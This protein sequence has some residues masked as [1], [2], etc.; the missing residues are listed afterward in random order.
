[1]KKTIFIAAAF[2][3]LL[4]FAAG[5]SGSTSKIASI[6]YP[7]SIAADDY[8]AQNAL[9]QQNQVDEGIIESVNDF[10]FDSAA[11]V[12]SAEEENV[13]YSPISLYM[14]L[15]MLSTGAEGD[16]KKEL[17]QL[18]K[19]A[20]TGY[21]SEQMGMLYRLMYYD[22]D[23]SKLYM[24]NSLW[25]NKDY[26]IKP[27]FVQN[28][29]DKFYAAANTLDFSDVKSGETISQWISDN[30]NGLLEP[31]IKVNPQNLMLILNTI[32]LNDQW[33]NKFEDSVTKQDT[34]Y[35][36]DG[37]SA[38]AQFMYGEFHTDITEGDGYTAASLYMKNTG[39]MIFV[40]PDEG[41]DTASIL[42]SADVMAAIADSQNS[43]SGLV[44]ISL[45]KFD[46]D[47]EFDLVDSLRRLGMELSFDP[48]NANFSNMTDM[49]AYVSGVKQ[50]SNVSVDEN[51]VE[52]AAYTAITI[53]TTAAIE[54]NE[55]IELKLNRPFIFIVQSNEGIP[56]FIGVV[57][58]PT[59]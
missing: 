33:S 1:M 14:A 31:E 41:V 40:L 3:V 50:G 39:R 58:N 47:S 6:A 52:A 8:E 53:N 44:K 57:Q 36:A 12:L 23:I 29:M 45:P 54:D 42:G 5:C 21:L 55:S 59:E 7:A 24:T 28:A 38:D 35:L 46:F 51:G 37:Q 20:D 34:F 56:L 16:T 2:F 26:E 17:T 30:T 18:L 48:N 19:V 25:M 15:A 43:R 22:N 49:Q 10:S 9:R 27:E 32:Y 4:S 11:V 13:C